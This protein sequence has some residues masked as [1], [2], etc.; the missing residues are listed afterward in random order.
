[1]ELL[2]QRLN[3]M[4]NSYYE[5]VDSVVDYAKAKKT[6]FDLLL[7]YMDNNVS[8]TPSDII[9]FISHQPDFHDY[10]GL[11]QHGFRAVNSKGKMSIFR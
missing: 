3:S 4:P 8:A 6:H 5:F 9:R 2:I 7:E 10:E 11:N 1:M